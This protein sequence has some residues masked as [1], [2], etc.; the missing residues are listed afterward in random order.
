MRMRPDGS[1]RPAKPP[2][3]LILST[4]ED[5]PRG[6]SLRARIF[7]VEVSTGEVK[8]EQ[9][10][11]CQE[12]AATG[13]YAEALVGFIRWL[14]P[15]YTQVRQQLRG[16]VVEL[17]QQAY[18]EG[19]HPRT[20]EIMAN[21][22]VGVRYF[23]DFARDAGALTAEEAEALWQRCW[24]G[25]TAAADVQRQYQ[26][27][28]EPTQRFIEL[29]SAALASGR[30]HIAAPNGQEPEGPE[31]WGWRKA[32]VEIGPYAHDDWRPQGKRVGW[33]DGE[34]LFLEPEASFA[35]VQALA[36]QHGEALPITASTLRKRLHERKLLVNIDE[37]RQVHTVRLTLEGQRRS[38]LHM[39]V[40]TLWSYISKKLDQPDQTEKGRTHV[41][42]LSSYIPK[43]PDQPDQPDQEA[44]NGSGR[45]GRVFWR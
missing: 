39:R 2:R 37:A 45:V 30:A 1:L 24:E 16:E 23:L 20:P 10:T 4:G 11:R 22:A 9:L 38:V 12:D 8:L 36:G 17:R 27:A 28:G 14:A 33:V 40:D 29:L 25:L 43:K 5:I 18:R 35:E 7:S 34:N 3:G 6:Q 42:T 19:Q 44:K 21:L 32:I 13:M 41:D 31:S 26:E 15:Q